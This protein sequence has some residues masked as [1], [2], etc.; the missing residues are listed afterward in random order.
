MHRRAWPLL[1]EPFVQLCACATVLHKGSCLRNRCARP[2]GPQ[3]RCCQSE[4]CSCAPVQL[5]CTKGPD[6]AR[7]PVSAA[8]ALSGGVEQAT[9]EESDRRGPQPDGH[10]P[11]AAPPPVANERDLSLTSRAFSAS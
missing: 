6:S 9:D 11:Q 5:C 1:S 4:L 3:A 10:H 7:P 8:A 2:A